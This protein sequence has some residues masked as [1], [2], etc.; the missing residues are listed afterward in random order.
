MRFIES[1][2]EQ[3]VPLLKERY[4][5]DDISQLESYEILELIGKKRGMLAARGEIDTER[6]AIMLLD[7]F[8]AAKIGRITLEEP[9]RI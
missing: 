9:E 3:Y 5:L 4:K 8:R 1:L 7:E 2:P 6:A